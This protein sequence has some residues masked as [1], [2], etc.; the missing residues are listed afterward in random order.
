MQV[1]ELLKMLRDAQMDD[2]AIKALLSEAMASLEGA[3]EKTPAAEDENAERAEAGKLL[4][5][6]L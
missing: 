4:G 5:V 3:A 6:S 2:E 1:E